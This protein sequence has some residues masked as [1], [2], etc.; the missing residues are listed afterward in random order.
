[1][2]ELTYSQ[3]MDNPEKIVEET[4]CYI[5]KTIEPLLPQLAA[6]EEKGMK[7]TSTDPTYYHMVKPVLS[8]IR[9][10]AQRS[11]QQ[12]WKNE[13]LNG[14]SMSSCLEA[15]AKI[16]DNVNLYKA[17]LLPESLVS[18]PLTKRTLTN[19]LP[20]PLSTCSTSSSSFNNSSNLSNTLNFNYTTYP[21]S[22]SS[23]GSTDSISGTLANC[24]LSEKPSLISI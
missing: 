5:I 2:K 14:K 24:T 12:I 4:N 19:P 18:S 13:Q 10:H 20:S 21:T 15:E 8:Q 23:V 9:N 17:L 3:T 1:M 6:L 16:V 22:I 7:K 11:L